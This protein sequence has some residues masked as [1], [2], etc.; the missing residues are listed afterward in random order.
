MLVHRNAIYRPVALTPQQKELKKDYL[1]Q[2]SLQEKNEI[3]SFEEILEGRE[4]EINEEAESLAYEYAR[5]EAD[6]DDVLEYLEE[7]GKIRDQHE[8]NDTEAD[9]LFERYEDEV[10]EHLS[11]EKGREYAIEHMQELYD[12]SVWRIE[13]EL[14][15]EDCWR[16]IT[17]KEGVD[18]TKLTNLGI[19]WSYD[20][21]AAEAHWAGE[22]DVKLTFHARIDLK[23]VNKEWTVYN[24]TDPSIGE[25]EKEVNLIQ[26]SPIFV[27]DVT[28]EKPGTPPETVRIHDWRRC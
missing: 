23:Y 12:E 22:G 19:Y 20:E 11:K 24:N 9:E 18:P 27:Y 10:S 16:E 1:L 4:H 7:N 2:Q 15:G 13:N 5:V 6:M 8:L 26:H 3:P 28:V 17:V 21:Y 14:D 25:S